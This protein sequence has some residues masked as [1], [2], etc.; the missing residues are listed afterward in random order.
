M[1]AVNALASWSR[2][3]RKAAAA[4]SGFAAVVLASGCPA[5][6]AIE[7]LCLTADR[8]TNLASGLYNSTGSSSDPLISMPQ[9]WRKFGGSGIS[10][11]HSRWRARMLAT[12]LNTDSGTC[13]FLTGE[14]KGL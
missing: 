1:P 3:D 4:V 9:S 5:C 2:H 14:G 6:C 12:S 13:F 7:P 10:K 8:P 11:L